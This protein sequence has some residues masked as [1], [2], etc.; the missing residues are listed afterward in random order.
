MSLRNGSCKAS[1]R[2]PVRLSDGSQSL[3]TARSFFPKLITLLRNQ[4]IISA[5]F[6]RR[7]LSSAPPDHPMLAANLRRPGLRR[8]GR[9]LRD[10]S[11]GGK[12]P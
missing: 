3:L 4:L 8:I 5:I 1:R 11:V 12:E 10:R 6:S 7:P 9:L 2:S